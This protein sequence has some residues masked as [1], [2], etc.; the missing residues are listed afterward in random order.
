MDAIALLGSFF[1]YLSRIT[2]HHTHVELKNDHST[3]NQKET[4]KKHLFFDK[5]H[6]I[7]I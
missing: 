5:R 4:T 3:F 2:A 1:G 6:Y 7:G